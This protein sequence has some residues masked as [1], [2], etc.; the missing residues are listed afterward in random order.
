MPVS[1]EY[2]DLFQKTFIE[3]IKKELFNDCNISS[4][5]TVRAQ[6]FLEK[7]ISIAFS[8]ISAIANAAS[9]PGANIPV[10]IFST[11]I[12][13]RYS[14]RRDKRCARGALITFT[15]NLEELD[16]LLHIAAQKLTQRHQAIFRF[17]TDKE[18]I[19]R[20]ATIGAKRALSDIKKSSKTDFTI[21]NLLEGVRIGFIEEDSGNHSIK[22]DIGN[23]T[24]EGIFRRSGWFDGEKYY[25]VNDSGDDDTNIDGVAP[26]YSYAYVDK[27]FIKKFPDKKIEEVPRAPQQLLF[28]SSIIWVSINKKKLEE[29]LQKFHDGKTEKSLRDFF[30][31]QFNNQEIE[32]IFYAPE[33]EKDFNLS[34]LN[35]SNVDCSYSVF[36]GCHFHGSLNDSRWDSADLKYANFS[37]IIGAERAIFNNAKLEFLEASD[38]NF[39][40]S[41]FLSANLTCAVLEKADFSGCKLLGVRWSGTELNCIKIDNFDGIKKQQEEQENKLLQCQQGLSECLAELKRQK[42]ELL[43]KTQ[44]LESSQSQNAQEIVGLKAQ[45]TDMQDLIADLQSKLYF[46]GWYEKELERQQSQSRETEKELHDKVEECEQLKEQSEAQGRT[47]RELEE[48]LAVSGIENKGIKEKLTV[49]E[50]E[51]D[52]LKEENKAKDMA[53]Q[54]LETIIVNYEILLQD[55]FGSLLQTRRH[56]D[57]AI[58]IPMSGKFPLAEIN[59]YDRAARNYINFI[60]NDNRWTDSQSATR[61]FILGKILRMSP[62]ELPKEGFWNKLKFNLFNSMLRSSFYYHVRK[63]INEAKLSPV[64]V[65]L[66]PKVLSLCGIGIPTE[67]FNRVCSDASAHITELR[68]IAFKIDKEGI[69][70]SGRIGYYLNNISRYFQR[71]T[72]VDFSFNN[73]GNLESDA[74]EKIVEFLLSLP[75]LTTIILSHNSL[76]N[77][78]FIFFSNNLR[79]KRVKIDFSFN[80]IN[81]NNINLLDYQNELILTGNYTASVRISEETQNTERV[82]RLSVTNSSTLS[83]NLAPHNVINASQLQSLILPHYFVNNDYWLMVLVRD[84]KTREEQQ[85]DFYIEGSQNNEHFFVKASLRETGN[86]EVKNL[87][88]S[89]VEMLGDSTQYYDV[90]V[91]EPD[92][93]KQFNFSSQNTFFKGMLRSGD[94]VNIPASPISDRLGMQI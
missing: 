39:Q 40:G 64:S 36:H 30:K 4:G 80:Q 83:S 14:K 55:L 3:Q 85:Y 57:Q 77:K 7:F 93:I 10:D 48:K 58:S 89:D 90:I 56:L 44:Y 11:A 42:E 33:S 79:D 9:L 69:F 37:N 54:E 16:A 17:I 49:L 71:L 70:Y 50:A 25:H 94:F 22:C 29:Y 61:R 72:L 66:W 19:V 59:E 67:K 27:K 34:G 24:T 62:K 5:R 32:K 87:S 20:L 52:R 51:N 92:K 6:T 74:L 45:M 63:R 81:F 18:E 76:G 82:T 21:E 84:K 35:F 86:L 26:K 46:N 78:Q 1:S 60:N 2:L 47:M 15:T 13:W 43:E 23:A 75:N 65:I 53:R 88:K 91:R 38:K 41:S 31:D 73:I 28:Q 8:E 68:L 12:L